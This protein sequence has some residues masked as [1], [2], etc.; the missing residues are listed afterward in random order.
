MECRLRCPINPEVSWHKDGQPIPNS[1]RYY[2]EVIPDP[3]GG[4]AL[5]CRLVIGNPHISDSGRYICRA[6]TNSHIENTF[7]DIV[8][9]GKLIV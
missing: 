3:L 8:Y 1:D 7:A 5:S 9:K 2:H 4:G 6:E